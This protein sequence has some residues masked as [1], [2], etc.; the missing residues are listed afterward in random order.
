MTPY[1]FGYGSLVNRNTHAYPDAR[2]AQLHGWHRLWVRIAG[3]SHVFL[4]VLPEKDTVI[5][6]LIAAVPGADWVALDTRETNYNRIGSNGAVVHDIIP[7][8]DMA[9]YSVPTDTHVTSGDHTILLSYIDVVVQGFLREYGVDGVQRFFDTT[10]GWDT[11]ILNDRAAPKYPRAQ[12]LTVQ[13][14]ALVDDNLTRLSA[15]VQ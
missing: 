12:A 1:F 3:A 8:P 15:Q 4:S 6:G 14:T 5:D 13:E 11:P 2:P 9:H 7:A 10:R